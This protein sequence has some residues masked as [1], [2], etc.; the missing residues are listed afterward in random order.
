MQRTCRLEAGASLR[1]IYELRDAFSLPAQSAARWTLSPGSRGPLGL[2]RYSTRLSL[3]VGAALLF[4][5]TFPDP[6]PAQTV[7][8]IARRD[9]AAGRSP[10]SVAV[11]DF[12]G[13][14]KLDLAVANFDSSDVSVLLGNGDG[15][16]IAGLTFGEGGGTSLVAVAVYKGDG[17]LDLA[18]ANFDSS[19]VSVLLGNGD[20]RFKAALTFGAGRGPSFVAVGDFNGD[21][22]LDLAVANFDSNDISVLLGN[23]DGS[24]STSEEFR[25]GRECRCRWAADDY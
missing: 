6:A 23:G 9:F 4:L 20:G 10:D 12:N 1:R 25:A 14:G 17:K 11:G 24:F 5:S 21:G 3:L 19:D 18:V 15:S 13:D 8:F 7:S 2:T 22:K 16:L